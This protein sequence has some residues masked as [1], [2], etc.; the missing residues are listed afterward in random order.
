M[1]EHCLA[2]SPIC[3]LQGQLYGEQRNTQDVHTRRNTQDVHT[4]RNTQDVLITDSYQQPKQ[5]F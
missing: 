4:R 1:T 2:A 3:Q 5:P